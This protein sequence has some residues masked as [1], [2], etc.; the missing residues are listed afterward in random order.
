MRT[1]FGLRERW[2]AGKGGGKEK[3]SCNTVWTG[4]FSRLKSKYPNSEKHKNQT[5]E[6]NY[7]QIIFI[8][9][10]KPENTLTLTWKGTVQQQVWNQQVEPCWLLQEPLV[11]WSKIRRQRCFAYFIFVC[12]GLSF[13]SR[14]ITWLWT[15]CELQ[16]TPN[17]FILRTS[18]FEPSLNLRCSP[19]SSVECSFFIPRKPDQ[20]CSSKPSP[21]QL[22]VSQDLKMSLE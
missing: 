12:S 7:T 19:S 13:S 15:F 11:F 16:G 9:A 6:T 21:K 22:P 8:T 18:S 4:D 14:Q 2:T 10:H 1:S 17:T 20:S 5:E 3:P